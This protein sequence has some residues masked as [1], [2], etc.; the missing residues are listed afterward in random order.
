MICE[1]G[2]GPKGRQHRSASVVPSPSSSGNQ[3]QA[4]RDGP[5]GKEQFCRKSPGERESKTHPTHTEQAQEHRDRQGQAGRTDTQTH[6]HTTPPLQRHSHNSVSHTTEP[7]SIF[8][9]P[10]KS[11]EEVPGMEGNSPPRLLLSWPHR[12]LQ[13]REEVLETPE[14]GCT[15]TTSHTP[16]DSVKELQ[17]LS[18]WCWCNHEH[19]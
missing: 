11:L 7:T 18:V 19:G 2:S 9:D 4:H 12:P 16:R 17:P 1:G 14:F 13:Q 10:C 5:A 3:G 8:F 6:R 15:Q